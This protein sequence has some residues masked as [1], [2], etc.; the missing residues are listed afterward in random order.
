MYT[1][2]QRNEIYKKAYVKISKNKE[3][4]I[5]TA[6]GRDNKDSFPEFE[7][8]MPEQWNGWSSL[9]GIFSFKWFESDEELLFIKNYDFVKNLRL[10]I[11]SFCIAM[12]E[13]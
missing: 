5:C 6:I 12:T 9:F 10:T 1:T 11:L 4:H 13:E 2:K 8:C 3:R 7:L